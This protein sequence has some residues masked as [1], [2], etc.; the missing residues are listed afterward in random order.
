MGEGVERV[1]VV[2]IF[3]Q[4]YHVRGVTSPE[5]VAHLAGFVDQKMREVSD[6]TP[7]VDTLKVA[8]LAALNIADQYLSARQKLQNLEQMVA[9][10]SRRLSTTIDAA[11]G[12][13]SA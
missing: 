9:E 3:G 4:T 11:L 12:Q 7:T 2:E 1:T 6:H 13:K 8:I 5:H 10:R